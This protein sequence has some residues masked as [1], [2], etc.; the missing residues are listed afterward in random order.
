MGALCTVARLGKLAPACLDR[1]HA[2]SS[3]PTITEATQETA[4]EAAKKLHAASAVVRQSVR[5]QHRCLAAVNSAAGPTQL[6]RPA[7]FPSGVVPADTPAH[8]FFMFGVGT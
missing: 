1:C 5:H 6:A 2:F 8:Q 3:K 4:G 7:N